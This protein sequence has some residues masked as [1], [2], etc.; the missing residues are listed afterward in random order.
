MPT[1]I[2]AKLR[3]GEPAVM[4]NVNYPAP[5]LVETLA[6]AG[7]D[8]IFIDCELGAHAMTDVENLVRAAHLAGIGAI[9][10]PDCPEA[11]SLA[12]YLARGIDGLMVPHV[13]G[14]GS[15][16][17]LIDIVRY[18]RPDDHADL[19]MVVMVESLQGLETLPDILATDGVDVVF[20]GSGD[21]AKSMGH[22]DKSHPEVQAKVAEIMSQINEGG[23]IS[24]RFV[25]MDNVRECAEAGVGL[26]YIHANHLLLHGAKVFRERLGR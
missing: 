6:A 10:R 4:V 9:L 5:A 7:A 21:L 26:L 25:T 8:A 3:R 20:C 14:V 19:L 12:R 11:W 17:R 13:E 22:L 18:F 1:A 2:K 16:A 15:A 24:G 23:R